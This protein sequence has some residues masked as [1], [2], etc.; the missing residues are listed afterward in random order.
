[1]DVLGL[2]LAQI[3]LWVDHI[4]GGQLCQTKKSKKEEQNANSYSVNVDSEDTQ[5]REHDNSNL[6][7]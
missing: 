2:S 7:K 4:K 3:L 1:M 6:K 5:N